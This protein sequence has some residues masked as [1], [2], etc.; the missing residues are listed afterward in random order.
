MG[1]GRSRRWWMLAAPPWVGVLAVGGTWAVGVGGAAP[2]EQTP[3]H[4][5]L[6]ASIVVAP[7]AGPAA[8]IPVQWVLLP[9]GR[10]GLSVYASPGGG[11]SQTLPPADELGSPLVLLATARQREWFQALLPSRPN[12]STGRR[13]ATA[14]AGA[15]PG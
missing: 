4:R 9:E 13:R 7:A 10:D 15:K 12:G 8:P 3:A 5:V 11:V 2:A 14:A 6:Q 1:L